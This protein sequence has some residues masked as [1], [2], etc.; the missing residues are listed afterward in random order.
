MFVLNSLRAKHDIFHDSLAM[1]G[2]GGLS[3]SF[4]LFDGYSPMLDGSIRVVGL[5]YA[6]SQKSEKSESITVTINVKASSASCNILG[7]LL[8]SHLITIH[9]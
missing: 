3:L 5:D 9:R 2:H 4:S 7:R 6:H 1:P 8:T